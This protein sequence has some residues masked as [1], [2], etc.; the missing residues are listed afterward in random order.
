M[1]GVTF[2][3]FPKPHNDIWTAENANGGSVSERA[4]GTILVLTTLPNTHTYALCT[5]LG[6]TVQLT[7]TQIL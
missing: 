1:K 6:G 7:N 4:N 2:V 5:L 3:P